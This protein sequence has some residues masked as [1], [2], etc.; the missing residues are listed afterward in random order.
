MSFECMQL[1]CPSILG[2]HSR[3]FGMPLKSALSCLF[4]ESYLAC[5]TST[6]EVRFVFILENSQ[7]KSH[8]KALRT[9][10]FKVEDCRTSSILISL[11][12]RGWPKAQV[13]LTAPCGY[14]R[15]ELCG[16]DRSEEHTSELQSRAQISY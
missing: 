10:D 2:K 11:P 16:T 12:D 4:C 1:I 14:R 5:I 8:W 3:T 6:N 13:C 9:A 7:S 15:V